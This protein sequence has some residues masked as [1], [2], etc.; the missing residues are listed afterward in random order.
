MKGSI[1]LRFVLFALT[2]AIT[3]GAQAQTPVKV[4][5]AELSIPFGVVKGKL[6][7]AGEMM[8]FVD[9]ENTDASFTIEKAAIRSWNEQDGVL[10]IDTSKPIK[11]RSGE[12]NRLAFRL[13]EGNGATLAAWYKNSAS[14]MSAAT[15]GSDSKP[16][17]VT[18]PAPGSSD[19]SGTKVYQ[20]SQKRFP[21]G[22][23]DGKL[24]ISETEIAFESL[25]DIKRS[26]RWSY[27]DIKEI[28]QIST[29]II[30][31]APFR[32]D[33]YKLELQGEG[34][35]SAQFKVLTD[36]IASARVAK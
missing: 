10:T 5:K 17:G 32:G 28:K 25:N 2:I 14:A 27:R 11:D 24:V 20:A 22:T 29:Y 18:A 15:N 35:S 33:K 36:R 21:I 19:L 7:A 30:E 34:M 3:I 4:Q 6:I 23:T 1:F 9:E 26:Q 31:I 16:L 12:R 8:I 13:V